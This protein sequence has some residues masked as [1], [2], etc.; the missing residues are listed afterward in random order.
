M[1]V[2]DNTTIIT[3]TTTNVKNHFVISISTLVDL[4]IIREWTHDSLRQLPLS[5]LIYPVK[6]FPITSLDTSVLLT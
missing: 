3:H 6:S 5:I 1:Y 4:G 2:T